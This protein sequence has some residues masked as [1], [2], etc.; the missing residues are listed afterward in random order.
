MLNYAYLIGSVSFFSPNNGFY[1]SLKQQGL[2]TIENKSLRLLLSQVYEQSFPEIQHTVEFFN[3]RF[4]DE[5][6]RHYKKY[7]VL[8]E[9]D[10]NLSG[11]NYLHFDYSMYQVEA[12][13]NREAMMSDAEFLEFVKI[14]ILFHQ[15]LKNHLNRTMIKLSKA[16]DLINNELNYARYGSPKKE[17]ITLSLEGYENAEEVRVT[18]EF[19]NWRPD[20]AMRKTPKGWERSFTLF[21]GVYEYK[22][23]VVQQGQA[24]ENLTWIVDPG[25][26]DS[27]YVPEVGSY[28][29][30]LTISE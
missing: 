30:V 23:I 12:L 18:G 7:F 2:E 15:N 5:R 4:S 14:S 22:F 17:D 29:S 13:K 9:N 25:N 11:V 20:G 28:N 1:E 27:V 16:F 26:R 10:R 6:I 24:P 19:N 21:P 3:E 8:S